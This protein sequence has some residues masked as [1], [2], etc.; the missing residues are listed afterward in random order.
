M[1][2]IESIPS[3]DLDTAAE[4][5]L[6]MVHT[7]E[8][9]HAAWALQRAHD[10]AASRAEAL[11]GAGRP[12]ESAD[13]QHADSEPR[14]TTAPADS[15]AHDEPSSDDAAAHATVRRPATGASDINTR[16]PPLDAIP[17]NTHLE[18]DSKSAAQ[19]EHERSGS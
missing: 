7:V 10:F 4:A 1:E 11:M 13:E 18:D 6:A 9:A 5:A 16:L 12:A 19:T 14:P 8:A 15:T 3:A 17:R 2:R